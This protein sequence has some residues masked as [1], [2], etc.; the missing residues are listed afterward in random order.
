MRIFDQLGR[1]F[2]PGKAKAPA[3][4]PIAAP[5]LVDRWSDYPSS[6]LTPGRLGAIFRA[7]DQGDVSR[8][9]ELFEEMEEKDPHLYSQLQTR[10]LAV[11]GLRWDILPKEKDEDDPRIGRIVDFAADALEDVDLDEA[12]LD[13]LDSVGKG[14][15]MLEQHWDTSEGQAA[16]SGWTWIHPKKLNFV[17]TITPRILTEA[18]ELRG[19]DP[20][21]WKTIY[22]RYK[23]RSGY[24]TRAGLIRVCAWMYLFKNYDIKDW[25]AF[26]EVYGQPLRVGK[27]APGAS[28]EDKEALIHAVRSIGSDAAG[29]ISQ[30]TEIEFIEAAKTGSL[31][32]F[33]TLAAFCDR[34][35]SKAILGQT[36]TSEQ[37]SSGSY[38][39]GRVHSEVRQDLVEADSIG[40]EKT[41]ARQILRPLVG[42]NFGW[43]A[44]VPRFK[45]YYEP[46]EDLAATATVYKTLAEIGFDLSQEHVSDRF[47]VPIRKD[48]ETPLRKTGGGPDSGSNSG[49]GAGP[50]A[51]LAGKDAPPADVG[52]TDFAETG[53]NFD[54]IDQAAQKA[55]DEAPND[56]MIEPIAALVETAG[57][58]EEIRDGILKLKL[59]AA[60][61]GAHIQKAMATA[62]LMGRFDGWERE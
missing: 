33:E 5:R 29:V 51:S 10:K 54:V 24:D 19:I 9:C 34:Q 1:I 12:I 18:D 37:G 15:S 59:P 21:P 7:A 50:V 39:L 22:H 38:A 61:M 56:A 53:W 30:A 60:E 43:E 16:I 45:L 49:A 32:I 55:H 48:G 27:Y 6:G 47:S 52:E 58:L 41:V 2:T 57:S 11:Q 28:P 62:R 14:F 31:D 40:I 4:R 3:T 13:M 42:Y 25:V 17:E 23:A 36:L 8:Q 46:P 44:P 35:M 20:P 26:A